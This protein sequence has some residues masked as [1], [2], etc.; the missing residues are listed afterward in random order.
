MNIVII[1]DEKMAVDVLR[2]MLEKLIQFTI[3]IKGTYTNVRDA[4]AFLKKNE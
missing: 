1:D 4:F 3:C 2:I